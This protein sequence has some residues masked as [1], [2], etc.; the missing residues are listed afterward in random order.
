MIAVL[1][2]TVWIAP[3]NVPTED[4]L[5]AATALSDGQRPREAAAFAMTAFERADLPARKRV[6]LALFAQAEYASLYRSTPDSP[7]GA[8][9]D[10][11]RALAILE[12]A[13]P[14]ATADAERRKLADWESAHREALATDYPAH[15]CAPARTPP[16]V[17]RPAPTP[18]LTLDVGRRITG[19]FTGGGIVLGLGLGSLAVT[20]GALAVRAQAARQADT[21]ESMLDAPSVDPAARADYSALERR[22]TAAG[23]TALA[24]GVLGVVATVTGIS[25]L[26]R[27]HV[28]RRRLH[29]A[30]AFGDSR[31]GLL[32]FGRF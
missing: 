20:A 13:G 27:G 19:H 16:H 9:E 4:P 24:T 28:L 10:L 8:P 25:V 12:R 22:F 17:P 2:A 14:L 1:L 15:T 7:P 29:A 3:A 11:C 6:E 31:L 21:Y 30:P 5:D 32:I 26:A 23:A 18:R